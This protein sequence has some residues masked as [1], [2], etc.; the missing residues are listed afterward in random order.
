M[1]VSRFHDARREPV[2][3]CDVVP[4]LDDN[5]Q[6]SVE[7]YRD[8]LYAA[9]ADKRERMRMRQA[10]EPDEAT[11]TP[12]ETTPTSERAR[13]AEASPK[14]VYYAVIITS[15]YLPIFDHR[16]VCLQ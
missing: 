11:P 16:Y 6:L 1:T 14:N 5:I 3:D 8:R 2:L 12:V 13:S 15:P 9:I 4:H 10:Q 7:R